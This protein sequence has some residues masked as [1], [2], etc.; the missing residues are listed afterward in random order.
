MTSTLSLPSDFSSLLDSVSSDMWNARERMGDCGCL[1][2]IQSDEE[3][4]L[5][6]LSSNGFERLGYGL[7]RVV[8]RFPQHSNFSNYVAKIGR[9]GNIPIEMGIFQNKNEIELWNT[10]CKN[11]VESEY[12]FVPVS[13]WDVD[14]KKWC[15]ME[16]GKPLEQ[17]DYLNN[18]FIV[19]T[20]ESELQEC[21]F[22]KQ[23]EISSE[24]IVWHDGSAKLCDLGRSNV[25]ELFGSESKNKTVCIQ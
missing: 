7:A 24:N 1:Y 5:E 12:P 18:E 22:I 15:V 23:I 13:S 19:D 10:L 3:Q 9:F 20:I 16:Y 8:Y 6:A 4:I 2:S 14:S 11:G 17:V 21:P 25:D